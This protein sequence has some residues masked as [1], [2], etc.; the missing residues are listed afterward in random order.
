LNDP[1]PNGDAAA[2]AISIPTAPA[3]IG[4]APTVTRTVRAVSGVT[5]V[6]AS[7]KLGPDVTRLTVTFDIARGAGSQASPPDRTTPQPAPAPSPP[8]VSSLRLASGRTLPSLLFVTNSGQLAQNLGVQESQAVLR[9]IRDAGQT[10]YDVRDPANPYVEIR[11][12]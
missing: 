1:T 7:A 5:E 9:A 2:P 10:V 11:G 12:Q 8:G 3:A 6:T 4:S